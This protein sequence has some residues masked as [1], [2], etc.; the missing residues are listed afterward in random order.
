MSRNLKETFNNRHGFTLVE[1]IVVLS[2][3]GLIAGIAGGFINFSFKA[4]NKVKGEYELQADLRQATE[5]LNNALRDASVTF[6][7]PG[8][9]SPST[10]TDDW[11]YIG[12]SDD[13]SEIVQYVWAEDADGTN[14]RHE[15]K[16]IVTSRAGITYNLTFDNKENTKLIGYKLQLNSTK[17][18]SLSVY[19]TLSAIN[20]VA[21]DINT[22]ERNPAAVVAYRTDARPKAGANKNVTIVISLVIDDSGS[23][24]WNMA[25]T[26]QDYVDSRYQRKTIM[27]SKANALIDSFPSNV[28]AGAVGFSGQGSIK[29]PLTKLVNTAAKQTV[30]SCI[31]INADG[32]TNTG[33][34]LRLAYYQ[35]KNY[36]KSSADEIVLY[37]VI[38]LTD[39]DPTYFSHT[40]YGKYN[41]YYGMQRR[42]YQ[43]VP[44]ADFQVD[45]AI[46]KYQGG[47]GSSDPMGNC[48]DYTRVVSNSLLVADSTL[49]TKTFVIGFS[50]DST[51]I[52][53][54]KSIAC[55][56]N[57][58]DPNT[59]TAEEKSKVYFEANSAESLGIAFNSIQEAILTEYWHIYG[60]DGKPE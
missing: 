41:Q 59:A 25:G 54:A 22:S 39:G 28:Y 23:M 45:S 10:V 43:E 34:G 60:P 7:R 12:V 47:T 57:G 56:C 24:S 4:E 37:Y 13:G 52:T 46:M 36:T 49:D 51:D 3:V 40:A 20:S 35:L 17:G 21:V 32:G 31:P 6:L 55:Y 27:K 19:S 42:D 29:C 50:G 18:K 33:D 48:L 9:V 38:M 30:E 16:T 1:L 5:N 15:V 44:D 8:S 11:S 14:G 58:L 53:K 2:L 26:Q